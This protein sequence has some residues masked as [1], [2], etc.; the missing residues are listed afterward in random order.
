MTDELRHANER[1]RVLKALARALEEPHL[2]LDLLLDAQDPD[3][4]ASALQDRFGLDE[5]QA[6]AI[7]DMQN[8]RL[9]K[10]DRERI[11]A[12]V[13]ELQKHIELLDG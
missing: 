5:V 8:R 7:L 3:E 11:R 13:E 1:L 2:V 10:R 12:D 6:G 4:A 9:T